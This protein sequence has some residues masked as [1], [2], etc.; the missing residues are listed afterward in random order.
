MRLLLVEGESD[1]SFFQ[2]VCRSLGL[3]ASVRVAPPREVQGAHNSKEGV[4][5]HLPV[6][7]KQLSDGSLER[8]AVVV[9]ADFEQDSGLGCR[10]TRER[11]EGI[12][13]EVGFSPA[14][15]AP[16]QRGLVF[17]HSDGFADLGLWIM[18]DNRQ[19]GCL[20]NFVQT[21]VGQDEQPLLRRAQDVVGALPSPRRF[22]DVQV[23]KAELATW[24]AWQQQP[25]RRLYHALQAGLIDVENQPF[26]GLIEWLRHIYR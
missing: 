8:L 4:F 20:E 23:G 5:K 9:D 6:L 18:P 2:E 15:R 22:K 14:K 26:V 21:C 10:R 11:V 3:Q 16:Q 13:R 19:D 25:G 7:L 12:L 17:T 24:M 1:K